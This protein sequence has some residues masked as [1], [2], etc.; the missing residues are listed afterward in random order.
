[1]WPIVNIKI[2]TRAALNKYIYRSYSNAKGCWVLKKIWLL[3]MESGNNDYFSY[4]QSDQSVVSHDSCCLLYI[5]K[6]TELQKESSSTTQVKSK[7]LKKKRDAWW[8]RRQSFMKSGQKIRSG[9]MKTSASIRRNPATL[10]VVVQMENILGTFVKSGG[11]RC[12]VRHSALW[13][14]CA[15]QK[16]VRYQNHLS[17]CSDKWCTN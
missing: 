11:E 5:M 9:A 13:F 3:I 6:H 2:L 16:P 8:M 4:S 12:Q 7:T 17:A 14:I 1:M 15:V 10:C